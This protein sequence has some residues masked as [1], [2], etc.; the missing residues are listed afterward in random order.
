MALSG[1]AA[2]EMAMK[3]LDYPIEPGAG[4]SAAQNYYRA[5]AHRPQLQAA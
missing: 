5:T 2:I 4:V 3:D 1:I